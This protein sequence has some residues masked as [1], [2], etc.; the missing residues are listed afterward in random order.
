MNLQEVAGQIQHTLI[1]TTLARDELVAHCRECL[2]YGFD[3]AMIPAAWVPVARE[4]LRGSRVKV[5]TAVDFPLGV[6]TTAGKAA[7]A[8]AVVAAGAQEIDIMPNIGFLRSGMDEAFRD[9][10]AAVV[11]AA[12]VPIKVML[13]LPLLTPDERERAVRLS[14]AAGVAWVKNAS[15]GA[16]GT[17]TPEDIAY[18]RK[19]VPASVRVKASG[20]IK[21]LAQ[22]EA[23]L[24]AGAELV[25]TSAGVAIVTGGAGESGY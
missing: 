11:Q 4:A 25:G 21:T 12:G 3:A 1:R 2:T 7:E 23:L 5:A 20:G 18:L 6:M 16:V 15:G 14:V 9:D 10:L 13:E 22:V 8:R 17:A 24:A 19:R